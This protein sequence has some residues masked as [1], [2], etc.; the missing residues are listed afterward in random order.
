M[1]AFC[2]SSLIKITWF[3]FD[4]LHIAFIH[5]QFGRAPAPL[6]INNRVRRRPPLVANKVATETE[7]EGKGKS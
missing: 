2:L 4:L 6:S 3:I 1:A 7:R 5:I